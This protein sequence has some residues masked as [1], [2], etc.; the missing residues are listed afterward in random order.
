MRKVLARA[1]LVVAVAFGAAGCGF[2]TSATFNAD[3]S[4][5][6]GLKFLFPK[7]LMQGSTGT[8]VSGLSPSDIAKANTQL[9]K[10]YPGGKVTAATAGDETAAPMTRPFKTA[11]GAFALS[12]APSKI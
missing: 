6:V 7:S 4:V 11:K 2:D 9:Q 8:T 1:L 10:Q 12:S 5:T 3:G